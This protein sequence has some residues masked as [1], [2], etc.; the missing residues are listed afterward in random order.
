MCQ[1]GFDMPRLHI[2]LKLSI[3]Q[4]HIKVSLYC[5]KNRFVMYIG[6]L[7]PV[8]VNV[9]VR[10][11]RLRKS[12]SKQI[13]QSPEQM[14]GKFSIFYISSGRGLQYVLFDMLIKYFIAKNT[15]ILHW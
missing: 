3:E 14:L 8:R 15:Y 10:G 1:Q 11:S 6:F 13:V 12:Y 2:Y 7:V 5:R 9:S 4:N